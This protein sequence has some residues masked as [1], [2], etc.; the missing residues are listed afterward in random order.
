HVWHDDV[1]EVSGRWEGDL[2]NFCL[3]LVAD[4]IS[5]KLELGPDMAKVHRALN[6]PQKF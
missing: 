1:L 5:K 2:T 6:I 4:D 3:L